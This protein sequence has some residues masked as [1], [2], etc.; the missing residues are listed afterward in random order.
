M[1]SAPAQLIHNVLSLSPSSLYNFDHGHCSPSRPLR[2]THARARARVLLLVAHVII[3][4]FHHVYMS[5]R[6][7]S[8][9]LLRATA[10]PSAHAGSLSARYVTCIDCGLQAC[11]S[12]CHR[13]CAS[14]LHHDHR[15]GSTDLLADR[16]CSEWTIRFPLRDRRILCAHEID[17]DIDQRLLWTHHMS[18][19]HRHASQGASASTVRWR[20][21]MHWYVRHLYAALHSY[22]YLYSLMMDRIRVSDPETDFVAP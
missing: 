21:F 14:L 5:C 2:R 6:S 1:T 22:P 9:M 8:D 10:Y 19:R 16:I 12:R 17:I 4:T 20:S 11:P 18:S 13:E 3:Q 15:A 7:H